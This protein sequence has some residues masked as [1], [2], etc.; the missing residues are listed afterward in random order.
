M[1]VQAFANR[2]EDI[3]AK[4]ETV[5]GTDSLNLDDEAK[6]DIF[7]KSMPVPFRAALRH[8]LPQSSS[9]VCEIRSGPANF[10]E[11]HRRECAARVVEPDARPRQR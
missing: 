1:T 3:V 4:Y 7:E 5:F 9:D 8:E 2:L 10:G 6:K 11:R